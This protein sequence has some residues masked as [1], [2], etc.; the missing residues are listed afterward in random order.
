ME[1]LRI[2]GDIGYDWWDGV[3]NSANA[4]VARIEEMKG[5]C[6]SLVVR[7][8]SV[9]GGLYDGLPIFNA[10]KHCPI[11]VQTVVDGCA[12]SMA[13]IIF[14]AGNVRSMCRASILHIHSP[15]TWAAGNAGQLRRAADELDVWERP[16]VAAIAHRCG[17]S[18]EEVKGLWFDGQDHYFSP[19]EALEAGLVDTIY[20]ADAE[21]PE[22]VAPEEIK[23]MPVKALR[24]AYYRA[25]NRKREKGFSLGFLMGKDRKPKKPE[26]KMDKERL[27]ALLDMDPAV[28]DEQ[29]EAA[30]REL[31]MAAVKAQQA[32]LP[33]NTEQVK[34]LEDENAGLKGRVEALEK[35]V[36]DLMKQPEAPGGAQATGTD[37]AGNEDPWAYAGDRLRE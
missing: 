35:T 30:V 34:R 18:E 8:N 3:D 11:P 17:R 28:G 26:N 12:M 10:L 6:A 15:L 7:I 31:K 21:F 16:L 9:G 27:C 14:Q 32:S 22:G 2:Y 19:E 20:D 5:R 36:E 25:Y 23:Y 29:I 37:F 1:E 13:G 4:L 24:E 33:E